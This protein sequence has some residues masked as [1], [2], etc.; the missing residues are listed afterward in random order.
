MNKPAR[1]IHPSNDSSSQV[2]HEQGRRRRKA[3]AAGSPA[4]NFEAE[5]IP[6]RRELYAAALRYTKSAAAAEDLVQETMLRALKAWASFEAGSNCRA[7]LYRILTNSFINIHRK[8]KRHHRFAHERGDDGIIAIYGVEKRRHLRP[9]E[10]LIDNALSDEVSAAL[11]NLSPDYR[12]VVELADIEGIRYKEIAARVGIPIGTVM[13]RLFRA[14]RQLEVILTEY[15]AES[16][17]IA[18]AA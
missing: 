13:S 1:R 18:R 15:A 9:D 16:Y 7:W 2:C 17:G 3:G 14:R 12:E 5:V 11:E 8:R 4:A 6:H 10:Q